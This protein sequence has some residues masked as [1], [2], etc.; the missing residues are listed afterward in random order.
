MMSFPACP[1]IVSSPRPPAIWSFPWL[2][3]MMSSPG[4]P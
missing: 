3:M 4:P 1:S 2:P